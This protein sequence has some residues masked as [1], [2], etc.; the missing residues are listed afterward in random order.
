MRHTIITLFL[1]FI[2]THVLFAQN[3]YSAKGIITDTASNLQLENSSVLVL[4][5]KDS[6]LAAFTRAATDGLFKI[7]GLANGKYILLVSYPNYADFVER[8]QLDSAKRSIDVGQINMTLKSQLLAEVIIKAKAVAI[9]IKGDTTEYNAAAYVIQPNSKVED[10]LKQLEGIQVDKD[11]KITAQGETVS[12]V[13]VDGEEFFGDDPTL[14]TKNIRADMVDKV[15]LYDK[16]SD[17]ATFTGIDDGQK[18]KT[19]NIKLKEDKKNGTFGKVDAGAGTKEFYQG[20]LLYNTFKAKQKIAAYGITSNTGKT[21]LGWDD[22][23]KIGESGMESSEDGSYFYMGGGG[24]DDMTY[25]GEGIPVARTGGVHFDK[26]WGSDNNYLNTNYKLG[27]LTIDGKKNIINQNNLSDKILNTNSDQTF[28]NFVFRH[29]VDGKYEYK[30]DSTSTLKIA[31]DATFRRYNRIN[32]SNSE[33]R[34][35][36]DTLQNRSLTDVISAGNGQ[37]INTSVFYTKKLKKTGR[38][39]SV[40]VAP[41]F[42]EGS[43][44]DSLRSDIRFYGKQGALDSTK[45]N[46][47]VRNNKT[48]SNSVNTNITYTEPLSKKL[49]V[50]LNYGVNIS[51]GS[52]DRRTY[53]QSSPGVYNVIVDKLS[54]DFE[55]NQL[56]N[57]AGAIF[58]YKGEKTIINFGTKASAVNFKQV[59]L[60]NNNTIKRDFI[61]WAPQARFTYRFSQQ[62]SFNINYTGQTNQPGLEQLQP[63]ITGN[64]L[65]NQRIGNPNLT[66]SFRNNL[67]IDYRSYK[68]LDETSLGLYGNYAYT[69]NPIVDN[70][71]TDTKGA[72]TF[73]SFNLPGKKPMSFWVNAYYNKK[74]KKIDVSVGPQ[75]SANGSTYYNMVNNQLNMT[76]SYNYSATINIQAYKVKKY[77]FYL[78]GGPSYNISQSSLQPNTNNNGRGFYASGSTN[79]YLPFKIQVGTN[80]NYQFTA[81]TKSFDTDF[82]LFIWNASLTKTFLKQDNLKIS[83]AGNDLLNNNTGFSRNEYGNTFTQTTTTTIKRFFLFSVIYEFNKMGGS[84]SKK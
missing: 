6:T 31:F 58:N 33:G 29:K 26:K 45:I 77:D 71:V 3:D 66:P 23:N 78:Y 84:N 11:G 21:T 37:S 75:L 59:D 18:S 69:I 46:D 81:K 20:Q 27:E 82:N 13:L 2:S 10:L 62:R 16:K 39:F 76:K 74:I 68:V 52:S 4:N 56:A 54:S 53:D 25:F 1:L 64:D 70:V 7:N 38:T 24:W 63:V 22:Q 15:Q 65:L 50:V 44:Q 67:R 34:I 43:D 55:L 14:V 17:Q 42:N 5:A 35:N 61:N 49:S 40:Y 8:F 9:K 73:Q 57:H 51:D 28:H 48:R 83:L 12:K 72:S 47:Q 19:I 32:N 30:I 60:F 80:F 79:I 36:F 41:S